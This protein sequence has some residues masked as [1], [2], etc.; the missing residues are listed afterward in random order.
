M[1]PAG[2]PPDLN[3]V[4]MT[5]GVGAALDWL[6]NE[7][8][9]VPEPAAATR[10]NAWRSVLH[11]LDLPALAGRSRPERQFII[12]GWAPSRTAIAVTGLGGRGK[13]TIIQTAATCVAAGLHFFGQ[14]SQHRPAIMFFG[15]EDSEDVHARQYD[16]NAYYGLDFMDEKNLYLFPRKGQD[17]TLFTIETKSA[18]VKTTPFFQLVRECCLDIKPGII[19]FDHWGLMCSGPEGDRHATGTAI[20]HLAGIA[21]D[22]D[23]T[24]IVLQHPSK[25]AGSTYSGNTGFEGGVR[26]LWHIDIGQEA[27]ERVLKLEKANYS[28][29]CEIKLRWTNGLFVPV[30]APIAGP[31][32]A[33]VIKERENNAKAAFLA[34]LDAATEQRRAV[35]DSPQAKNY[36]PRFFVENDLAGGCT[37]KELIRAMRALFNEAEI[38]ANQPLWRGANRHLVMGIARKCR[39]DPALQNCASV[40]D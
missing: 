13:T 38:I 21:A 6:R 39:T 24:F 30:D 37:V 11:P 4:L 34:A 12:A 23:G 36:A 40:D 27:D 1:P 7:A 18:L 32:Q 8:E 10:E 15:E 9:F 3:E 29:R 14:S 33:L 35:S 19:G 5:E 16:I 26:A 22:V 28:G 20:N 25:A 2:K 17:N 31:F